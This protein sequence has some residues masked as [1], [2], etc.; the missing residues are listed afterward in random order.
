MTKTENDF[1]TQ[2]SFG[3]SMLVGA[4]NVQGGLPGRLDG[5]DGNAENLGE[6]NL[7]AVGED[8]GGASLALVEEQNSGVESDD[9]DSEDAGLVGLALLLAPIF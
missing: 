3:N 7:P 9:Q 1:G 2:K 4:L 5:I 8:P 6:A